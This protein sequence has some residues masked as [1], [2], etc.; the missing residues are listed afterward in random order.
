M[1]VFQ[2]PLNGALVVA[3]ADGESASPFGHVLIRYAIEGDPIA[4]RFMQPPG[5]LGSH[6]KDVTDEQIEDAV[7]QLENGGVSA[8]SISAQRYR[9]WD[10]VGTPRAIVG[11]VTVS[12]GNATAAQ[13]EQVYAAMSRRRS[14]DSYAGT[15]QIPSAC[16]K[17]VSGSKNVAAENAGEQARAVASTLG[18]RL[19]DGPVRRL[20]RSVDPNTGVRWATDIRAGTCSFPAPPTNTYDI[21]MP[22]SLNSAHVA[23]LSISEYGAIASALRSEA[24]PKPMAKVV[25][26]YGAGDY[27]GNSVVSIDPARRS[28]IVVTQAHPAVML[29]RA[30][31]WLVTLVSVGRYPGISGVLRASGIPDGDITERADPQSTAQIVQVRF[32]SMTS[33]ELSKRVANLRS[34]SER[35]QAGLA[36]VH[37][38]AFLTSCNQVEKFALQQAALQARADAGSAAAAAGMRLSRPVAI[39]TELTRGSIRCGPVPNDV[40]SMGFAL[41]LNASMSDDAPGQVGAFLPRVTVMYEIR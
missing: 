10:A 4:S 3:L 37:T 15:W 6:R 24:V 1:I 8:R 30:D 36:A 12:F 13:I 31:A 25:D 29:E 21:P 39:I 5:A 40:R 26:F 19:S 2:V 35:E 17:L 38:F 18:L 11:L 14:G 23:S 41:A 16:D 33:T 27:A 34:R 28:P 7:A 22:S 32:P 20:F 9:P